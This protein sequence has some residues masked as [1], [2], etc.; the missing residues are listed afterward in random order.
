MN[1]LNLIDVSRDGDVVAVKDRTAS[2]AKIEINDYYGR[3]PL[4]IASCNGHL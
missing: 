3:N 1:Q 2:G 4:Y